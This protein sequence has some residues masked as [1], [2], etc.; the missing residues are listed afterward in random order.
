ME[1]GILSQAS[2]HVDFSLALT[3]LAHGARGVNELVFDQ[4]RLRRR[5][6]DEGGGGEAGGGHFHIDLHT[7][8]VKKKLRFSDLQDQI[9]RFCYFFAFF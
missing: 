9:T 8:Q 7:G 2:K 3:K 1:A 6:G 4:G 5:R